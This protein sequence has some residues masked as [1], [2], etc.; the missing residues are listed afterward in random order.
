MNTKH[1]KWQDYKANLKKEGK[2]PKKKPRLST[3]LESSKSQAD[4]KSKNI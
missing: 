1:Q 3:E 2:N 4:E